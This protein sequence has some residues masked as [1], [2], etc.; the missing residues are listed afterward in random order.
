VQVQSLKT[1]HVV[2][3]GCCA[4]CAQSIFVRELMPL[5]TG[6]EFV[7]GFL[8]AGW[9]FWVGAG[10]L[11]GARIAGGGSDAGL[12]RFAALVAI[13]AVLLPV[14]VAG[15]RLGRG[16]IATPP[17][18]FP[19]LGKALA[20]A[21]TVTAP[22]AF[23][24]GSIYNAASVLWKKQGGSFR[25]GI[26]R[27]YLWEAAGSFM[28]ALLF[29]FILIEYLSQFQAA[30]IAA[31]LPVL[32]IVS[33]SRNGTRRYAGAAIVLTIGLAIGGISPSIDR[34]SIESVYHGYRIERFYE[35]R[36]G[37]VVVAA[38]REVRSVFSGGGRLFS[39]PEPERTEEMIHIPLL[40]C[41]EPRT[42]LLIG[43][44]L[45]GGWEEAKKHPSVSRIECVELDGSLFGLGVGTA[46]DGGAKSPETPRPTETGGDETDVR[47]IAADGR[48][49]LGRAERRYDCIILSSPPAVN[50]QWNRFYTREFF[51]AAQRSLTPGGVFAF[52]HPSSENYLTAEQAKVLRVIQLT[53][54]SV[55]ARVIV[56]PGTTVHFIASDSGLDPG[57]IL[58]RLEE[59]GVDA[60]FV[61]KDYLPFRFTEERIG[62]LRA[63][64]AKAGGSPVNT[65]AKPVLPF[66]ELVLE[67]S[68]TGSRITAGFRAMLRVPSHLGAGIVGALLLVLFAASGR[69]SRARLAVWGVGFASFLF[70]LLVFLSYQS[71]S[72]LLYRGIVM[73]TALFMAGA[74]MGALLSMRRARRAGSAG[75]ALRMIHAGFMMLAITLALWPELLS[76]IRYSYAGGTLACTLMA[77]CGGFLTGAYYPIVVRTAFP[78]EGGPAP[79]TF[80]A[81]D[82]FGACAGGIT[83][84][85]IFFPLIGLS[86]TAIFIAFVHASALLL[87]AGR[88]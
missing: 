27:V 13:L 47:F 68:K 50:L 67:G 75:T 84:G 88:W 81:W 28:G 76:H 51:A 41:R 20:F 3:L 10:A 9:L 42:V 30:I 55:F 32:S 57:M 24:Y 71:F 54:E 15:I 29:S 16:L 78:E 35:S 62:E 37:E 6:T 65:D 66:Y 25:S 61:G 87:L 77:A 58:P 64:L 40:L 60:P 31:L 8:L 69:G 72:G 46:A 59:R 36:Y 4:L 26:S 86:G 2:S 11:A 21:F 48:F 73:L 38:R 5:F 49:Y 17:G 56:L 23:V 74:A 43:S 1:I 83:G 53:L 39:Y 82:V 34:K 44:S 14:T 12:R 80:Y 18:A 22:F 85:I 33:L 63:D 79:G 7:V 45:G 70:Q 19:P 52:T